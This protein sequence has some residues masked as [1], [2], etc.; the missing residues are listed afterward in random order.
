ME[1]GDTVLLSHSVPAEIRKEVLAREPDLKVSIA[2]SL[3][4][5]VGTV[6]EPDA[7]LTCTLS[8]ELLSAASGFKWVQ[9]LIAGVDSFDTNRLRERGIALTSASGVH[10]DPMA[11][12]MFGYVFHFCRNIDRAVRQQQR[13]SWVDM[14]GYEVIGNTLGIVGVGAIGGR[15]AE[16]GSFLGMNVVGTKRDPSTAPAAVDQIYPP[17]GLD[18][19]LNAA[20]VLVISCPLAD[21]TRGLVG[22]D[23]LARLEHDAILVNVARGESSMRRHSWRRSA[24]TASV[25]L[26]LTHLKKSHFHRTPR[27]GDS[28]MFS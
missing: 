15:V 17:E 28:R 7:I 3:S 11:Q 12:Q 9:A 10:A 21:V 27:C 1:D 26:P 5:A 16:L 2:G 20:D 23:E 14:D 24:A 13:R 4:E 25:P 6:P 22:A 8:E 18:E 19:V